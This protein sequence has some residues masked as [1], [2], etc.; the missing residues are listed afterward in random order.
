MSKCGRTLESFVAWRGA[1]DQLYFLAL[2]AYFGKAA[3]KNLLLVAVLGLK[4]S[5]KNAFKSYYSKYNKILK[6][7]QVKCHQQKSKMC[8]IFQTH[9]S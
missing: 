9:F 3:P 8:K 2:S 5:S 4:L 6:K 1:T 7:F